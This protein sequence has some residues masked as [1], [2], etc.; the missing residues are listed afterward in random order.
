MAQPGYYLDTE[1]PS[2]GSS[3]NGE[4]KKKAQAK[5]RGDKIEKKKSEPKEK[6]KRAEPKE[7][8]TA[9]PKEPK[10]PKE[11]RKLKE[12]TE[13]KPKAQTPAA[14]SVKDAF[15][16]FNKLITP[17]APLAALGAGRAYLTRREAIKEEVAEL[18]RAEEELQKKKAELE[19]KQSA[20]GVSILAHKMFSIL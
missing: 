18:A 5:A 10:P 15:N 17:L 7:K 20:N 3:I 19:S 9:P 16:P 2:Y 6:K 8:K 12:K 14:S 13:K 1:M 11:Q 4:N